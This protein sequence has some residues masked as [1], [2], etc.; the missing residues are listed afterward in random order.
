MLENLKRLFSYFSVRSFLLLFT[1]VVAIYLIIIIANMGGYMDKIKE[2]EIMEQVYNTVRGNPALQRLS[3]SELR[4]IL[5]KQIEI[6]KRQAGLDKPFITRSL[7]YLIRG[8]TLNFGRAEQMTS[9]SGSNQVRLILLERLPHTLL[10]WGTAD[11]LVFFVSVFFALAL[12]RRYGSFIDR[13]SVSLAPLSTPPV[14]FYGIL[15]ILL[16]A[17]FLRLLP[18]GGFVDA[19]PPSTTLAYVLSVIKHMIL[20]VLSVFIALI[21]SSL[22]SWRTFFLIYSSE[23]YVEMAKAKGLSSR[24]IERR[25]IL[26]PTLPPIVTSF[27]MMMISLWMGGIVT[28]TVF[29]WPGLGRLL[30]DAIQ[31]VD[32]PVIVGSNVIYGYLLAITVLLLDF[33]YAAL[34]PRVRL[35]GARRS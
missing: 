31:H 19:P 4:A 21:F 26:R 3:P 23:D 11:L 20:P 25:Y 33:L 1:V 6:A 2:S 30:Y 29:A 8:I 35:G 13:L 18:Y 10:L 24:A 34:D 7:E 5:D 15:L 32:T 28:E 22:Y 17:S 9:D 16:F 27:A 12:S 14:W